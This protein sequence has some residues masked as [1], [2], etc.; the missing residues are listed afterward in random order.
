MVFWRDAAFKE[1][2]LRENDLII[3]AKQ[4][5]AGLTDIK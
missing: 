3:A 5:R 4:N 2:N 1:M